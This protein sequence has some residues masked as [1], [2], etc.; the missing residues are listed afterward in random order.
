MIDC[1]RRILRDHDAF[2]WTVIERWTRIIEEVV[3]ISAN[4]IMAYLVISRVKI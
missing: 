1:V 4:L 2:L 3:L